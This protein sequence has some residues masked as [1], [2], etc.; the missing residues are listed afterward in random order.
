MKCLRRFAALAVAA[1]L[2]VGSLLWS[3]VY[4]MAADDAHWPPVQAVLTVLR[5]RS[6]AVRAVK[7][8]VPADLASAERRR[9]G[10]GNYHAMCA[11]CHLQP[12]VA[13]SELARGLYP[14]PPA[15]TQSRA[16]SPARDFWIIRH[17][18]KAS[19]MPAW[20]RSMSDE[21]LWN[22]TAF[23][24]EL[25]SLSATDYRQRVA[26]SDGHAHGGGEDVPAL[27]GGQHVHR[28]GRH[29]AH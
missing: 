25:P 11:G 8:E 13:S 10:A 28:D 15:L 22:L 12:G 16:S 3:G 14:S 18:I 23:V 20:G 4:N 5:E 27:H 21:H 19:G 29:H 26:A 2:L 7:L 24:Q 17:G 1:L 9:L 6:I